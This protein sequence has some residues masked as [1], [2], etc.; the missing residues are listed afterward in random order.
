MALVNGVMVA[1]EPP[2]GYH[3]DLDNP[4]RRGVPE[5]YVVSAVFAF[6]NVLFMAQRM[7]TKFF[8]VKKCNS[9]DYLLFLAFVLSFVT[10]GLTLPTYAK[11][12]AGLH[13]WELPIENLGEYVKIAYIQGPVYAACGCFAKLSLLTF[14][15]R[16]SPQQWFII[17]TWTT[18]A[19]QI[20]YTIVLEGTLIFG[21]RP[22]ARG[23]DITITEG[24]CLSTAAIY[25]A[26]AV[27]NIISDVIIL[28]LPIKMVVGLQMKTARKI[29]LLAVFTIGSAT[30][31]TGIVRAALLPAM[32]NSP[33]VTW[34]VAKVSTWFMVEANLLVICGSMTTLRKCF[35]HIAPRLIGES[36]YA[37]RKTGHSE[38][39]Q[40]GSLMTFGAGGGDKRK[41]PTANGYNEFDHDGSGSEEFI[42]APLP[43]KGPSGDQVRRI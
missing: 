7:Y 42:M 31:V 12:Q 28:V 9:D 24:Q 8:I 3:V 21:C 18:I 38:S 15:L 5:I 23:W 41:R 10:M 27:L 1:L 2:P 30:V 40:P 25:I 19:F 33:D 35:K 11:K 22:I 4:Q 29:G 43:S 6:L 26:T 37:S 17:S 20:A 14:Y 16:L 34:E 36:S 32:L 13:G 39:A